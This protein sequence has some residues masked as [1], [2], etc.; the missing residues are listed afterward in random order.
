MENVEGVEQ[1]VEAEGQVV[2]EFTEE[3]LKL[4]DNTE[5][6]EANTE[7]QASEE[8]SVT[9]KVNKIA[10]EITYNQSTGAYEVPEGTPED[11]VE[12]ATIVRKVTE[13]KR[14][15]ITDKVTVNQLKKNQEILLQ[16]IAETAVLDLSPAEVKELDDL[17]FENPDGWRKRMNT[18]EDKAKKDVIKALKGKLK[19]DPEQL[20]AESE[21]AYRQLA[22]EEHNRLHP[23]RPITD[24]VIQ[25]DIPPRITKQF[26][27]GKISIDDFLK[28]V[29]KYLTTEKVV[30]QKKVVK[31]PNLSKSGGRA[32]KPKGTK[33]KSVPYE[34][35]T[36]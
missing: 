4:L 3:E 15:Q 13:G 18:L 9:Q 33:T 25:N 6:Q 20:T 8:L 14:R 26:S 5:E 12:L 19:V 29:D 32:T 28:K 10:N 23:N 34:K 11:L 21:L 30:K 22:L 1:E 24:D 36:F 7:E 2:E 27:E 31:Q 16:Q 35:Q 17:K